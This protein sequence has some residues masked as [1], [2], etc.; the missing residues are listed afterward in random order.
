MEIRA[1]T[2]YIAPGDYHLRVRRSGTRLFAALDQGPQEN[3]CRPAVDVLFRSLAET[4]GK[5][6]LS[7]VLTGMGFDGLRGTKAIK[8]AGGYSLVQDQASS[9]V[10]GMPGAVAE[11]GLA[12]GVFPLSALGP[13]IVRLAGA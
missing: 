3:S 8:V 2:V 11:A 6:A 5:D 4:F 1:G 7:A 13:E 9:V 12:D 10:W